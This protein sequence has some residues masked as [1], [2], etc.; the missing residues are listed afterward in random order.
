DLVEI[1]RIG[2]QSEYVFIRDFS[3]AG[4]IFLLLYW[5]AVHKVVRGVAG[6]FC[7]SRTALFLPLLLKH[8]LQGYL[9]SVLEFQ[10]SFNHVL[11]AVLRFPIRP[12]S[13]N[14]KI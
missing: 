9:L 10:H 13:F 11:K 8:F 3:N 5:Y 14:F 2:E 7:R 4:I 12:Q 1:S 6:E